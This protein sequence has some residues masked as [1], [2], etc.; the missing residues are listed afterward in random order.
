MIIAYLMLTR[1]MDLLTLEVIKMETLI[2]IL[3]VLSMVVSLVGCFIVIKWSR[4]DR[5]DH[6]CRM[7]RMD[8]EIDRLNAE[9]DVMEQRYD[10][11]ALLVLHNLRLN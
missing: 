7:T 2:D 9:S 10:H 11:Q 8:R 1:F 6:Q 4:E 5:N 3:N